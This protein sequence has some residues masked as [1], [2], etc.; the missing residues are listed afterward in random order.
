MNIE[1]TGRH[2]VV[3]AKLR[4]QAEVALAAIARVTNRCTNAHMSRSVEK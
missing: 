2:T 4:T 1:F 3:T